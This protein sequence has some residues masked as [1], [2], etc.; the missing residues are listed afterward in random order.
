VKFVAAACACAAVSAAGCG[1]SDDRLVV[2]GASSLQQ[3]FDRYSAS[4][5][6]GPVSASYEG[7]DVLAAQIQHGARPDVFASAD[8]HYPAELFRKGL[9]ERP[10][11]FAGNRLVIAVPADSDISSL[12]DLE[13]P[14]IDL[15]IG[16]SSV[17]VGVYT[18]TV[19]ARLGAGERRRILGNVRSRESEV[20]SITAKL[21]NGAADAG[22][23]YATDARA[24][25]GDLRTIPLPP[26]LQP[27]VAYAVAV[28]KG[29]AHPLAAR[30]FVRGLIQ[31]A[32]RRDLRQAGF[33]P[34]P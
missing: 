21:V 31:G 15:V 9:V 8:T 3:A 19:L 5:E 18:R 2:F 27:T 13:R 34:P 7:S 20:A 24:A 30:R 14:G 12:G 4:F 28:V 32:G 1:G 22:F 23:V 17:P 6:R 33:L 11:E 16:D 10:R 25:G 26:R 29:A